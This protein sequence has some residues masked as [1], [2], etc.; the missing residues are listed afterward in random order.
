MTQIIP[1]QPPFDQAFQ[2][3]SHSSKRFYKKHKMG[4]ALLVTLGMTCKRYILFC[5][6][7]K[8]FDNNRDKLVDLW[9]THPKRGSSPM[10]CHPLQRTMTLVVTLAARILDILLRCELYPYYMDHVNTCPMAELVT[11]SDCYPIRRCSSEGR[12]F[13]P[14]WGS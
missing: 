7:C 8:C 6:L 1:K 14:H 3:S 5:S 10:S 4:W 12:E 11:A 2:H 9:S 13:E